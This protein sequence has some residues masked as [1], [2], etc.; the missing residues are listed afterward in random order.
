MRNTAD[1]DAAEAG[2]PGMDL[3]LRLGRPPGSF[4]GL[5]RLGAAERRR[6]A[7]AID[8][9]GCAHEQSLWNSLPAPLRLLTGRAGT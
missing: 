2:S 9:A 5:D 3:A 7:M 1:L 6:L 8:A 4:P